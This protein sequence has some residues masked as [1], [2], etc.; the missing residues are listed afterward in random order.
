MTTWD[1]GEEGRK[2]PVK[3]GETWLAGRHV[4]TCGSMFGRVLMPPGVPYVVY[5]DPPWTQGL[6]HGFYTKA[7]LRQPET[8]WL[9]VYRRIVEL[10]RG[11]PCFMEGGRRQAAEVAGVCRGKVYESWNITY[12]HRRSNAGILHYC[13][14]ELPAGLDLE[15]LDDD[16]TPGAVLAAYP[17]PAVVLDPCCGRGLTS[18]AAEQAGWTSVNLELHPARMSAALARLGLP[19]ERVRIPVGVVMDRGEADAG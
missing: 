3:P 17:G 9:D 5:A 1:Y 11:G 13:G 12:Y 10:S 18:R 14:P 7:G 2:Y 15:G 6:M 19:A 8:S 4:F 16:D